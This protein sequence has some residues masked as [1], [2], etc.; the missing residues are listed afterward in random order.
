[1][2]QLE[3]LLQQQAPQAHDV[4]GTQELPALVIDGIPTPVDK[5]TQ[6]RIFNIK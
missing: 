1:M 6:V 3:E 5:M 2:Q 4:P